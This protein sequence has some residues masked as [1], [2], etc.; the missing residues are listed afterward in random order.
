LYAITVANCTAS[1]P[2]DLCT[3][4]SNLAFPVVHLQQLMNPLTATRIP[5]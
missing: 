1:A 5:P 2:A 3:V 4:T